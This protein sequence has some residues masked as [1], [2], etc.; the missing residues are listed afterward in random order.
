[1]LAHVEDVDAAVARLATSLVPGGAL[2]IQHSD[3]ARKTYWFDDLWSRTRAAL[4]SRRGYAVN[5]TMTRQLRLAAETN[6]LIGE[7]ERRYLT[8][9]SRRPSHRA[10]R[11]RGVV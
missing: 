8:A 11:T 2:V 9:P 6:R 5:R 3:H 7:R 4:A 10:R 1:V